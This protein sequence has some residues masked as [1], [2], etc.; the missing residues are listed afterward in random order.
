MEPYAYGQAGVWDQNDISLTD[1]P[2][3][4]I[5]LRVYKNVVYIIYLYR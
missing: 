3:R 1:I 4:L 2:N 5:A